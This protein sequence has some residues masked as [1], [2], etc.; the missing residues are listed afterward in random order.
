ISSCA[1]SPSVQRATT[2]R[3]PATTGRRPGRERAAPA[4]A[5]GRTGTRRR[6]TRTAKAP[7]AAPESAPAIASRP[8]PP[9]EADIRARAYLIYLDR[10]GR[11]GDATSDWLQAEQELWAAYFA[12]T[13]ASA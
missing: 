1:W 5:G 3:A 9:T 13:N 6:T 4:P 8:L 10:N 2:A 12:A 7:A 11:P